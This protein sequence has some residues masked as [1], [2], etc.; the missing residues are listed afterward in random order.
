MVPSVRARRFHKF[1]SQY[2]WDQK[3]YKAT[4]YWLLKELEI[5]L[6]EGADSLSK[7]IDLDELKMY[8]ILLRSHGITDDSKDE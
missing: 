2:K 3:Q 5:I 4:E 1:A 8:K 7:F 6:D